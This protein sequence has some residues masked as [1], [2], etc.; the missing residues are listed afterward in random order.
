MKNIFLKL[1]IPANTNQLSLA[2]KRYGWKLPMVI[3]ERFYD[4]WFDATNAT[5]TVGLVRLEDTE[6]GV[7]GQQIGN[8]YQPSG[9][10]MSKSIL[11]KVVALGYNGIVDYGSGKGQVLL[12]AAKQQF[13]SIVGVEFSKELHKIAQENI[14]KFYLK[15]PKTDK[16]ISVCIDARLF[17]PKKEHCV[18][19]FFHPFKAPI[20]AEVLNQIEKSLKQNPRKVLPVYVYPVCRGE[21]DLRKHWKLKDDFSVR[22][23][24]CLFYEFE[25]DVG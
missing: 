12:Q 24:Q 14:E 25:G 8:Q 10:L 4:L 13:T 6:L 3:Y 17:E 16:P 7:E 5:D 2:L 20:L 1:R 15:H 19:Y 22:N 18:F 21:I 23:Y 9:I 11:K